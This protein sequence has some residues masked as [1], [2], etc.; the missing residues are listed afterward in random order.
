MEDVMD[1]KVDS[2]TL[3]II[4]H[5][6]E[7]IAN[8]MEDALLKSAFSPIVKEMR[9]GTA[10]I[11]DAKARTV[12]Q[13]M[14][15]PVHLG[16]LMFSV[17]AIIKHF[18]IQ[19]AKEG[20]IYIHN[21]PYDG[22]THLPDVT[23]VE[24][25]I[26]KG[27]VVA[28]TVS[29]VHHADI[30]GISPGVSTAATSLYQE[31]L[32]LPPVKLYDSGKPVE[33]IWDIIRKN[34][35][36]PDIVF[37]DL[38]AQIASVKVGKVRFLK[39]FDDYG[40]EL[41]LSAMDQ[42]LDYSENLTRNGLENIPDGTY[43]FVDYLDNDGVELDKTVRIE[44]AVTIKGSEFI[45]D[46]SG[47]NPQ[48]KGPFNCTSAS[49]YACLTYVLKIITGGV[50][51]PTN[52]GCFR[53]I[54]YILPEGSIVNPIHPAPTGSRTTTM[55]AIASTLLGALVKAAPQYINACSGA[56]GPLI[57]FGGKDPLN[58]KDYITNE[59][60]MV[61]L[62][63]RPSKDGVDVI[64]PDMVN[65]LS[66]PV[67]AFEMD[68]PFRVLEFKLHE[69]SGGAGEYRGGLGL[70]K[71]FRLLRGSCSATFRGERFYVPAWGLFGGLPGR[72]GK[73]FIIRK[74]G[75]RVN[76]PSKSDYF[77]EEG[78]ELGFTSSGG[79][80][81]GNPLKRKPEFVLRDVLDGRVS[82]KAAANDYGVIIN[83]EL[84][85]IEL[86]KTI[87]LRKEKDEKRGFLA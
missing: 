82:I 26:Y 55:Q 48:T 49:V 15:I 29:M 75:E 66:I 42:L 59:I 44:V 30:G 3:E 12:S 69:D 71:S 67:E 83:E 36:V 25:V 43:S 32:C 16:C 28:L 84:M 33:A 11:F 40:K 79:G 47:S 54:S 80:G 70:Q 72:V 51:I 63:A 24:P 4:H 35:R 86:E 77:L 39:L 64:S 62:G 27:E 37:G 73:G 17:P 22:G 65:L 76:I 60:S 45:A 5:R 9:D 6:L 46:F 34:V 41:V 31:G 81:Y 68:Y 56:Y 58:N 38:G 78:D 18:P 87:E 14:A 53:S 85:T 21:D 2:I 50:T 52:A 10:A 1:K 7:S 13:A 74:N 8:E 23:M 20:D 19:E 61:G 57:Y